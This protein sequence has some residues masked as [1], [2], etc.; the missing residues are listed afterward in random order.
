MS[1][2][3]RLAALRIR[4]VGLGIAQI[5]NELH[6]SERVLNR[7]FAESGIERGK[8]K[9]KGNSTPAPRPYVRGYRWGGGDGLSRREVDT[10]LAVRISHRR[11]TNT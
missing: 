9:R 10:L 8:P 7:W 4:A 2:A 3:A 5:P 11:R 1:V 6:V